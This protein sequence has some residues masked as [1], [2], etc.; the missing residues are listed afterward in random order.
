MRRH[1]P[2]SMTAM[3]I[4]NKY[5]KLRYYHREALMKL[6]LGGIRTRDPLQFIVSCENKL[7]KTVW[8]IR[9]HLCALIPSL[10]YRKKSRRSLLTA[11]L[12]E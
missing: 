10:F 4:S 9:E 8:F 3:L 1:V 11:V 2:I 6:I 12:S 7:L 5:S